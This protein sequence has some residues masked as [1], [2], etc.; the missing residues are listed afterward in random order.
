MAKDQY[1]LAED[2]FIRK[3]HRLRELFFE[4]IH[5]ADQDQL[6][7]LLKGRC[8]RSFIIAV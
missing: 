4:A 6:K 7:V 2:A 1:L 8:G 5:Q 3:T